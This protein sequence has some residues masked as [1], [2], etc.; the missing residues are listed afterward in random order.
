MYKA[1][2]RQYRPETLSE[3]VGQNHIVTVL[4]NQIDNNQVG[5]AYLFCG[6]RGTGK[7]TSARLL[8]KGVNCL[9]DSEKPCGICA[10]CIAIQEGSFLDLIEI[11]AASNNGVDD[12]RELR[13]NVNF[14]PISGRKKVYIIDEAHMLS[15][16]A[17]NAFLKTLEEPPEHVMFILAT[18]EPHT[19]PATILS[20]CIRM[21][22]RRVS[23][24]ILV[25]R[26]QLICNEKNIAVE[27]NDLQL[28]AANADGSV[29]DALTLLEQ[30]ISG[31]GDSV[32]RE[33][34]L[35]ALGAVD[36][37]V[38][39]DIVDASIDKD[40]AKVMI[41]LQRAF[42]YGKEARQML[43]GMMN[44]YRNLML[45]KN[46]DNVH[47]MLNMSDENIERLKIQS[48]K[49]SVEQITR[50][51]MKLS[52]ANGYMINTSNPRI[53]FETSL[54]DIL[55]DT[56]GTDLNNFSNKSYKNLSHDEEKVA[57]KIVRS[58]QVDE[59]RNS[60]KTRDVVKN[61]DKDIDDKDNSNYI[62]NDIDLGALWLKVC[63]KMVE[64]NPAFAATRS[65]VKINKIDNSAVDL[66]A[67]NNVIKTI[68]EKSG[69]H[70]S[71]K[72]AEI[73]GRE[74]SLNIFSQSELDDN[75][76]EDN[77]VEELENLLGIRPVII[78]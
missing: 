49:L 27:K 45:A 74:I 72:F 18:T 76:E 3:V 21:D 62:N 57:Q 60:D 53:V 14:P 78:D 59:N 41:I 26:M 70:L 6:T 12:I 58:V 50:S 15:K 61:I 16:G 20:R 48:K 42:S 11:D 7:T 1:I 19:L 73:L 10:N 67:T 22:F 2:Y 31:R 30:C 68:V 17:K 29:R 64:C 32:S 46:I 43:V 37:D 44:H 40:L 66:I 23:E 71:E 56:N 63:N 4:K 77:I 54:I 34:I 65:G 69:K 36:D 75:N 8:A 25:E 51:V 55:V 35:E 9:S 33:D 52:E 5:H 38:Y 28:I 13:D 47:G 39:L 24:E